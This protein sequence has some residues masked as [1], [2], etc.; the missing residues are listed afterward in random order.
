[1]SHSQTSATMK[2]GTNPRFEKNKSSLLGLENDTKQQ[3]LLANDI[4]YINYTI[5][6][7]IN[8][9]KLKWT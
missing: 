8:H 9:S 5:I 6:K 1:M 2:V 3:K 4:S 7:I